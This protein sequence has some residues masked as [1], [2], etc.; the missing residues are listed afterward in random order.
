MR[1]TKTGQDPF[2]RS[3]LETATQ[4]IT[5]EMADAGMSYS[6][7][8]GVTAA[9][10]QAFWRGYAAMDEYE[11]GSPEWA[12]AATGNRAAVMTARVASTF[13]IDE[14][15]LRGNVA[16]THTTPNYAREW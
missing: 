11:P 4:A 13:Q 12:W 14:D 9:C 16:N 2:Y 5:A 1:T 10:R 15:D 7:L 6:H 3:R 8:C